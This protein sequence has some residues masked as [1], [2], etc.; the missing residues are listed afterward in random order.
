MCP[1]LLEIGPFTIYGYGLMLGL[2][3]V[4]A[5]YLLTKEIR[6]KRLDANLASTITFLALVFGIVGSKLFFLLENWDHFLLDPIPM[7]FSPSGLTWHGGFIL[8]TA[9]IY[10]YARRKKLPF[11]KICDAAAPAL[12]LGYGVARIGCHL[13]GDGD[14]GMPTDLPWAAVYS[15]GTYPPSMAFRDFPEVVAQYGVNGVVPD[16][17][18]VHPTPIYEFLLGVI[19]FA[20]LWKLRRYN[21]PDGKLFTYYL[22]FAGIA[23]FGVEFIRLNPRVFLGLSE[24]QLISGL[25]IAVGAYG[26]WYFGKRAVPATEIK[27][28]HREKGDS[29]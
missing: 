19:F 11:L 9:S 29:P 5:S 21:Y 18:P 10:L 7:A 3:F 1:R 13:A 24:A 26:L 2:G 6:R 25:L 28:S 4:I 16:D 23:R 14:Y 15:E 12:M 20:V 27:Q 8:A 22:V 17:L